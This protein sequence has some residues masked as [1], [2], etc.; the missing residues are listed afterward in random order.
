[1]PVSKNDDEVATGVSAARAAWNADC[2][3][4]NIIPTNSLHLKSCRIH[5]LQ[6]ETLYIFAIIGGIG[7]VLTMGTFIYL[8]CKVRPAL[9]EPLLESVP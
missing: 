4:L 1:M 6:M 3:E 2:R 5:Q 8:A 7:M 9:S